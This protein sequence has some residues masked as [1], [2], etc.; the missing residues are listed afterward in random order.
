[1][2]LSLIK[3]GNIVLT[4]ITIHRSQSSLCFLFLVRLGGYIVNSL[5]FHF[6]HVTFLVTL[7][8]KV[9]STLTMVQLYVSHQILMGHLSLQKHISPI[10]LTNISFINLVLI[11]RCSSS[12]RNP[13]YVRRVDF[14][15]LVF[16]LSSHRH[17]YLR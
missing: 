14:S 6:R 3:Y 1:M 7:K 13:V 9:G 4:I 8:P 17:S 2:R 10:T 15:D 11:F 16:S 12:P 5:E